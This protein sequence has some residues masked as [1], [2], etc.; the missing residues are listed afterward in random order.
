MYYILFTVF[1]YLS[2]SILYSPLIAKRFCNVDIYSVSDDGNPGAANVF[3]YGDIKLGILCMVL[4]VFKAF[5]P[6]SL[7]SLLLDVH[8]LPFIL[9]LVAPV[10]G[11]AMPVFHKFHGG[12][13]IA[14]SF[15][16]LLGL[17]PKSFIVIALAAILVFFTFILI[18]KPNSLRCII[19]YACFAFF[20]LRYADL[21][22]VRY[23]CIIIAAIV[24]VRHILAY[25]HEKPEFKIILLS[26]LRHR[27]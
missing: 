12:K 20:C 13:A 8:N 6:V 23:G 25:E 4:D 24:I 1:G 26:R 9:V 21:R 7:A 14:A 18:I 19:S 5:L 15:G 17:I 27:N 11:H 16:C 2:G 10:L 3:K 22:T